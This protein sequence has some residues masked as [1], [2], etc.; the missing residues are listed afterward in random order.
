MPAE[1]VRR[2][3][4][5]LLEGDAD[6]WAGH[7]VMIY[8]RRHSDED[9]ASP[10]PRASKWDLRQLDGAVRYVRRLELDRELRHDPDGPS[11]GRTG[12]RRRAAAIALSVNHIDTSGYYGPHI[13]NRLI[14][15]ALDPYPA[16]LIISTKVGC[17]RGEDGSWNPDHSPE[18]QVRGVHD[19]LHNLRLE[20]LDIVN[21][22]LGTA[23][24]P[25]EG[26]ISAPLE[27]EFTCS[28]TWAGPRPFVSR[29]CRF[30]ASGRPAD[31]AMA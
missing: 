15:E 23:E 20:R 12:R 11:K 31:Q 4:H 30:P 14:K 16:N 18:G 17:F 10:N 5:R 24:G 28:G 7:V 9:R 3:V 21:L 26:S 6:R 27:E 25:V 22:R 29:T 19:N 13:T 2:R 8:R 1:G